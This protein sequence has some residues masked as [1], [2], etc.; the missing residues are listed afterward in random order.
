MPYLVLPPDPPSVI[1]PLKPIDSTASTLVVKAKTRVQQLASSE[2]NEEVNQNYLLQ[3]STLKSSPLSASRNA[4]LLGKPSAVSYTSNPSDGSY[5]QPPGATFPTALAEDPPSSQPV[6][7]GTPAVFPSVK[8]VVHPTTLSR[9]STS[10]IN[11]PVSIAENT[12]SSQPVDSGTPAVFPS[13]KEVVHPSTLSRDSASKIN[14]SVSIAE[15]TPSSQ[16]V[17]SIIKFKS[18]SPTEQRTLEFR[19][20]EKPPAVIERI[21]D[22]TADRQDYDTQ[23]QIVTAEGNVIVRYEGAVIDADRLQ[24]NLNNLIAVGDGNVALTRGGQVLRGER[25]TYN[26]VQDSGEIENG[27]G[28][29]FI[30]T[31]ASDLSFLPSDIIAGGVPKYPPSDR[32]RANQP[33]S[34]VS[35]PGELNLAIG[36]QSAASNVPPPKTGGQ[37]RRIRFEAKRIDFYSRGWQARDVR[38]TNDPFSPPELELR[39]SQATLT[40]EAPL[41]DKIQTQ[42]QRLVFDQDV[43][44]PLPL[45]ERTIDRRPRQVNPAI[46][47]VG[48]DATNLSGLYI[49]HTFPVVS[50][51][52]SSWSLTPQFLIQRALQGGGNVDSFFGLKTR[53]NAVLGPKTTLQGFGELASLD[54][55]TLDNNLQGN[56]RLRQLLGNVNPYTLTLESGYRN[57]LYNGTLGYQT[58]QSNL[59][60]LIKS[61]VIPLGKTGINLNYQA[62]VEYINANTDRQDLLEAQ[63]QT[64]TG[65]ISLGRLQA[66]FSL[67][68]GI[69]LW[70]GKPL[71]PT[72]TEG[73][74]YTSRPVVPY[75]T[76]VTGITGT[77][78]YYTSGDQQST[79]TGTVGLV[80]QIGHF[81]RHYL[82]YTAFN[83]IYS[84]GLNSGS[85]PFLFDRSVDNRVLT[86]GISQQIYGPFR[87]GFEDSVELD[88]AQAIST[89]YIIEYSRRTYGIVLRYNPVLQ[90]GGISIRI[91]DFNWSGGTDPFS[92]GEV[93]SVVRGVIQDY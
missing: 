72:A 92:S 79:L 51:E 22:V 83:L 87:I 55:S 68:R 16:P 91:S 43:S 50:T 58:V 5:F 66:S 29:I 12:P 61:P 52:N 4:A 9:D 31:A 27:R 25:F 85:S 80:G 11:L 28:E 13:V 44:L 81:S 37:V 89:D 77:S 39:A 90:L 88:T 82:D 19:P 3:P 24:V 73:L 56:L 30:P 21:V 47:N 26:L 6:D 84:Q 48:Y 38:I 34:G 15:N 41:I 8:E 74:H 33:T 42:N 62:G 67:S 78:S 23:R 17:P 32:I 20:R 63:G 59:G 1:A 14:L 65:R 45:D 64:Q 40:R 35:S 70:H 93:K 57:L 36:G 2:N 7:S 49:E 46:V 71:P 86:A 54:L 60:G 69:P 18:R 53:V 76:L 10:K 75:L